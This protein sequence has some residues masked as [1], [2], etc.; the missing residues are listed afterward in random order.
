MCQGYKNKYNKFLPL[1]VEIT[2]VFDSLKGFKL[3]YRLKRV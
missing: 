2:I 3:I 1:L